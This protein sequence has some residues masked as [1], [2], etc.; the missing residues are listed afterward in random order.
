MAATIYN[1]KLTMLFLQ[2]V[3]ITKRN[4]AKNAFPN[5]I[6]FDVFSVLEANLPAVKNNPNVET[7]MIEMDHPMDIEKAE[8]KIL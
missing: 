8:P 5:N 1:P 6:R 3:V 4:N 7:R 2:L